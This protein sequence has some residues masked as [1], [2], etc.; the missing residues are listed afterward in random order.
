MKRITRILAVFL[1]LTLLTGCSNMMHILQ[2]RADLR[3]NGLS[4]FDELEYSRPDMEAIRTQFEKTLAM[5]K[6]GTGMKKLLDA[7]YDCW[8]LYLD[9]FTMDT[10]AELRSYQDVTDTFYADEAAFCLDAEAE[11]DQLFEQL[12]IAGANCEKKEQLEQEF[13]GEGTLDDYVGVESGTYD[14]AY[15]ALAQKEGDLLTEYR[16]ILAEA[17]VEFE[18]RQT[19]YSELMADETLTEEQL[20]QINEAYYDK[21]CDILGE[22][23]IDLIAVRQE[24]AAYL[25]YDSYE[26]LAYDYIYERDYTPQQAQKLLDDIRTEIAPLYRQ[27]NENAL[28]DSVSYAAVTEQ[29]IFNTVETAAQQLGEGVHDSIA[30]AFEFMKKHELYDIRISEKK[31]NISYQVYLDR[32]DVPFTL[33]KTYGYD[34]DIL[35][36]AHEFGHFIDSWFNHNSTYSLELA[37]VFSQSMEYLLLCT[38]PEEKLGDLRTIKLL[39]TLDTYAQQGSFAAFERAVYEIPA[40]ELT[41]Q[42]L[43]DLSLQYAIDYGYFAEGMED[44]YAKSWI[45]I[46][47][48]FEYPFYVVSY[49]VSNDAAFQIYRLEL[50]DGGAGLD[51]FNRL[52]PRRYDGFLDSLKNQSDLESPFAPGRMEKTADTVRSQLYD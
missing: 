19:L 36:F 14:D 50:A 24:Q 46:T 33:V 21:Y 26:A 44:Y 28:W 41:V 39:D 27:V 45:D 7:L 51:Q 18:G 10:V 37:E 38:M 35:A 43:N 52:L 31:A 42:T 49:C 32:Y 23:Y 17:T 22:L 4:T 29:E 9:F 25:G 5:H 30:D 34:D 13:W 3:S 6:D 1:M 11:V 48:F 47:H 15:V 20:R 2:D 40:E 16:S 8:E 12:Q